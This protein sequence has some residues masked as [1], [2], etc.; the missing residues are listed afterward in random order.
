[1]KMRP[2][3]SGLAPCLAL[4]PC[5]PGWLSLCLLQA[6]NHQWLSLQWLSL[7]AS[8]ALMQKCAE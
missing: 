4:A 5:L 8:G 6:L 3:R 2:M 7:Q 1:M